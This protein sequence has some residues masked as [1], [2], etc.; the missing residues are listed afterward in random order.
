M[1]DGD[2]EEMQVLVASLDAELWWCRSTLLLGLP[3]KL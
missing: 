2:A 1:R 3:Q